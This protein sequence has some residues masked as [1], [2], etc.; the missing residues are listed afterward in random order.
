VLEILRTE[1]RVAMGQSGVAKV[2]DFT[3]AHVG[4]V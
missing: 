2:K 3:P 1:F 4:R